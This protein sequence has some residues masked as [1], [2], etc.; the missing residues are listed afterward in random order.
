MS[1]LHHGDVV[2]VASSVHGQC[3]PRFGRVK[4]T[5]APKTQAIFFSSAK[6]L[7]ECCGNFAEEL[8]F[9]VVQGCL[10]FVISATI[11]VALQKQ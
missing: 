3:L 11:L 4:V 2:F 1:F 6:V 7:R 5:A 8:C 9:D 10:L